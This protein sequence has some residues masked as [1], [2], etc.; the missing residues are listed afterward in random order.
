[1]ERVSGVAEGGSGEARI[2]LDDT[3]LPV[4][5]LAVRDHDPDE[6][7]AVARDSDVGVVAGGEQDGVAL[8]DD[9]DLRGG[10]VAGVDELE[11][12]GGRGHLDVDVDLFEHGGVL[13]WRPAGP[14]ARERARD[15]RDK[16]A[17]VDVGAEQDVDG[18]LCAR[19]AG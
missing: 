16:A 11:T 4:D 12:E 14:V 2:D 19:S 17:G 9:V 3:P 18:T 5:D 7:E 6:I 8:A 15:A 1:M 10:D 13:V